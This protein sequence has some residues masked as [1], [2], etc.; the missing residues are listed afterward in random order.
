MR[1]KIHSPRAAILIWLFSAVMGAQNL[2]SV[3]QT[4]ETARPLSPAAQQETG[5]SEHSEQPPIDAKEIVRQSVEV[6][7]HNGKCSSTWT[8]MAA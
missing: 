3:A 1:W 6:D 2:P 8:S 4:P 5:S 7:H